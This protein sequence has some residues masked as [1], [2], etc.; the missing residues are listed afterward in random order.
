LARNAPAGFFMVVDCG[1]CRGLGAFTSK[2]PE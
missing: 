1:I 2:P